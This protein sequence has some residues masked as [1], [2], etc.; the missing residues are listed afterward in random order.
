[1]VVKYAQSEQKNIESLT[2]RNRAEGRMKEMAREREL[3]I[4]RFNQHKR[5]RIRAMENLETR[6]CRCSICSRMFVFIFE[7]A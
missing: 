3:M 1:M 5:E 4:Q 2:I 6:V 7:E